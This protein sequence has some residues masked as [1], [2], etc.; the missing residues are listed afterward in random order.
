MDYQKATI[1]KLSGI[2]MTIGRL[3]VG[4]YATAGNFSASKQTLDELENNIKQ[5]KNAR[6][7]KLELVSYWDSQF[8]SA[9]GIYFN[10]Q[11]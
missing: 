11:G 8:E 6:N 3:L 10:H 2:R 7:I 9:R 1:P 5:L 4:Y